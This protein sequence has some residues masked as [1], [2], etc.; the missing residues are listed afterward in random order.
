MKI[1]GEPWREHRDD[2]EGR[3]SSAGYKDQPGNSRKEAK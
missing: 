3:E 1:G 2:T